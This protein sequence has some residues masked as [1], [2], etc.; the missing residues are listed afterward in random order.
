MNSEKTQIEIEDH[1]LIQRYLA[2][3][4]NAFPVLYARYR[5]L[6]FN[7]LNGLLS[8]N[9]FTADDLFQQ[10]W[11][12]ALDNLG[13]YREQQQ[14]SAWLLRIAHNLVIDHFRKNQS[15][16][17]YEAGSLNDENNFIDPPQ[18]NG[19]PWR[20]MS[21]SELGK[22]IREALEELSPDLREVF[23]LRQEELSFKEIAE[24]QNS[25][26]NT[27]LGR[28][29]YALKNLRKLLAEWKS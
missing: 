16:L 21:N 19:E 29:Q 5:E 2:G 4:G 13:K 27:V 22:A 11:I 20:D 26:I 8:Y 25:S 17:R 3:D 12:R 15:K 18:K 7:Y 24:I 9:S 23:L 1:I 14:F 6:L 28:M 10:T